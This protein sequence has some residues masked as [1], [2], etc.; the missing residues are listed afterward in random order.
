MEGIFLVFAMNNITSISIHYLLIA[1][2]TLLPIVMVVC[3][4][5]FSISSNEEV[6]F[7]KS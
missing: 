7:N 1:A 5:G 4:L 3:I 2:G 6:C